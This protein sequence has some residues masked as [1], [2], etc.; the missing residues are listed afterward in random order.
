MTDQPKKQGGGSVGMMA[1]VLES[2]SNTRKPKSAL[3]YPVA[4]AELV[5]N[6]FRGVIGIPKKAK[7]KS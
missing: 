4:G 6:V 1:R 5:V 7:K 3:G 2:V